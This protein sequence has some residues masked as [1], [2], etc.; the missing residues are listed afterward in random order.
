MSH[1]EQYGQPGQPEQSEQPEQPTRRDRSSR[2]R[3]SRPPRGRKPS[4]VKR[5]FGRPESTRAGTKAVAP[6]STSTVMS[7]A[8]AA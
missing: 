8:T 6:G 1:P 3:R 7:A 4:K 5:A 2:S